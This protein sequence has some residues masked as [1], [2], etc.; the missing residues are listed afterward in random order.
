MHWEVT[1]WFGILDV[2]FIAEDVGSRAKTV[3]LKEVDAAQST[4]LTR[5]TSEFDVN[6]NL[7]AAQREVR[8]L[9]RVC[10]VDMNAVPN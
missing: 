5:L 10:G 9:A 7:T 4:K 6:R 3:G 8:D 2:Q 1:P